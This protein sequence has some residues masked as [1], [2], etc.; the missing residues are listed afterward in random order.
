MDTIISPNQLVEGDT[1]FD[2]VA[3]PVTILNRGTGG[4][5]RAFIG[6]GVEWSKISLLA[7]T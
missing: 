3:G 7:S 6:T 4:I 2:P 5:T 1:D